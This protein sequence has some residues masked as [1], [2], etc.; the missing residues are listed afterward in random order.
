MMRSFP[1]RKN[2]TS[3]RT[4]FLLGGCWSKPER[5]TPSAAG[6]TLRQPLMDILY[7][8]KSV[9]GALRRWV[10]NP[11]LTGTLMKAAAV[12]AAVT[13]EPRHLSGGVSCSAGAAGSDPSGVLCAGYQNVTFRYGSSNSNQQ[14]VDGWLARTTG[15]LRRGLASSGNAAGLLRHC[16][17]CAAASLTEMS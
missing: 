10:E 9:T 2:P 11:E 17:L 16:R 6:E 13:V 12:V 1:C 5:R 14:R 8:V 3:T 7:T 4:H 15:M